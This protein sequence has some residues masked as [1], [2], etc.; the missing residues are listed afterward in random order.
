MM[1][2]IILKQFGSTD[3]FSFADVELPPIGD[4]DVLVKIHATAFNPIDYQMRQG[5]NESKILHSPILG[6]ECSGV[7][8]KTGKSVKG[9]AVG[10]SVFCA[11]GSMGSNG[12]YTEYISVPQ[13]ILAHKPANISFEEAASLP[14]IALT[15]M[16]CFNRLKIS[17]EESVFISGG[18]GGVGLVL[19]KILLAHDITHIITTAGNEESKQ[20]LIQAG[21]EAARIIDYKQPNLLPQIIGQNNN[22]LFDYCID[23][24]GGKMSELCSNIVRLNGTYTDVTALS[25]E[26]ARG[27]L[28]NIGA[29]VMNISNYAY[30]SKG[31]FSYYGTLLERIASML[32][33]GTITPSPV[34]VVGG[35]ALDTVKKAHTILENNETRGRKLV[36]KIV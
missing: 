15:A 6:R 2:A 12:T 28:F 22:Q 35:F 10:D 19:I 32:E 14:V 30:S 20:Q 21:L 11:S 3:N 16:Q 36:M 26:E 33:K 1:K 27:N 18:A 17:P 31:N 25:T 4:N 29:V 7:I 5:A 13:Q 23:L 34:N 9:F 24:V 8:T